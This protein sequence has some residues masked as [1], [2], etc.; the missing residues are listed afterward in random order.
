MAAAEADVGWNRGVDKF[1]NEN[2]DAAICEE[3]ADP[4]TENDDDVDADV[5][6]SWKELLNGF[7]L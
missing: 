4:G 3:D 7:L 5:G 6:I 1:G 2:A